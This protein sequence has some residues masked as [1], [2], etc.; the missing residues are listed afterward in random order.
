VTEPAAATVP[1]KQASV[2]EDFV[3][4]FYAPSSVFARRRD[5]RWGLAFVFYSIVGII[6]M[7]AA[8]PMLQPMFDQ[9]MRL[10]AEA[11]RSN[12]D[13]S[14]EQRERMAETMGGMSDS[15]WLVVPLALAF[16]L[17]V[18][19]GGVVLWMVSKLFGSQQS[20]GQ[21]MMVAT[22]SNYPRLLVLLVTLAIFYALGTGGVGDPYEQG[23]SPAMLL[24]EGSS[25]YM[26]ALF[27]RLELGAIW[28]TVLMGIGTYTV[29]RVSKASAIGVAVVMWI[30][31]T[32]AVMG[33]AVRQMP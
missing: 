6:L 16:P 13:M 28:V 15:P 8:R 17:G 25:I 20:L 18:L 9:Q 31:A 23:I 32:L 27:S 26:K 12:P 2:W 7:V 33:S 24:P 29:G 1:A 22:Y 10:Q 30:L 3:D 5:G 21:S 11:M 4:I 14:A 19:I